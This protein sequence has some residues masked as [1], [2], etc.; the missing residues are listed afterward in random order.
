M[1]KELDLLMLDV[2]DI[3]ASTY[4]YHDILEFEIKKQSPNWTTFR[5]GKT[6]LAIR[7]Q[8]EQMVDER[9]VKHGIVFGFLCLD[10]DKKVKELE[11][12]GAHILL[13][14]RDETFGRYAEIAD[15]DGHIIMLTNAT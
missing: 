12:K 5:M 2:K 14:P 4:F 1:F 13:W 10:V 8:R 6:T 9:N 3:S 15:P 7:P 11:E